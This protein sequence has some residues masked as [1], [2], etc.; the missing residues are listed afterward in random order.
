MSDFAI[1]REVSGHKGRYVIRRDGAEGERPHPPAAMDDVLH[2][3]RARGRQPGQ[4]QGRGG[5]IQAGADR[6]G[7]AHVEISCLRKQDIEYMYRKT[8]QLGPEKC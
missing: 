4:L 5:R 6:H 7:V 3:E 2:Q 1:E 8:C